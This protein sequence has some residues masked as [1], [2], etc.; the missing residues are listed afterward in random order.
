MLYQILFTPLFISH[1]NSENKINGKVST[2]KLNLVD[3]AG[4]ERIN[5]SGEEMLLN[6]YVCLLTIIATL[7][8]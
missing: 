8:N 4:S 7:S 2:G 6:F 3:L 5:K 1:C